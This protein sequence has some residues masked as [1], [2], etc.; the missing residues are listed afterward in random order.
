MGPKERFPSVLYVFDGV[1]TCQLLTQ[2]QI[3]SVLP[4]GL[5]YQGESEGNKKARTCRAF[6]KSSDGAEG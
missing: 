4:A 5:L 2:N 6:L 3:L 1:V